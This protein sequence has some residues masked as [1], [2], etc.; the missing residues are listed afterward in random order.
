MAD[1]PERMYLSPIYGEDA[2]GYQQILQYRIA[3][4]NDNSESVV[5]NRDLDANRVHVVANGRRYM[6][7]LNTLY[8]FRLEFRK[9][10]VSTL[11]F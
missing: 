9:I 1:T 5:A 4:K 2:D 8:V 6:I 3:L 10:E 11:D 7:D